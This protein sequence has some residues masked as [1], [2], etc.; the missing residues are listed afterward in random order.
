[1][2]GSVFAISDLHSSYAANRLIIDDL[3][4]EC[5][6]DW[7]IVAGDVDETF[8]DVEKALRLL[9]QRYA[10]VIWAPGNHELW[11]LRED[12]V[13]LRGEA[14]YRAL[15]QMCQ[16]NDILT[17]EDEFAIWPGLTSPITIVP[18]FQLYD[19]SWLAPG[20]RTKKE[21]LEYAYRTGA[22]CTDEML[23]HPDPYPDRESWC[24]ARLKES[25]RRL[26]ALGPDVRTVLV[27]HWPLVRQPTDVLRFPEFAQWCGTTRTA[28]WHIRFRAEVVVY[29]HL[30]IPRTTHYDGVRFEEVSLGYPRE[31][32]RRGKPP[33]PKKVL[34]G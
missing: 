17:P 10:K 30:H 5:G 25:E 32:S 7:L 20:T 2:P 9:R 4:P 33:M 34:P 3:R 26:V 16:E 6:D 12:P 15:V 21:S 23:L 11:T 14:R 22:V 8:A 24:G 29:G 27:S 13:Q 18:L 1:V 31:W 19:H 28:D